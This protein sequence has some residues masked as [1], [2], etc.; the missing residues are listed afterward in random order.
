MKDEIRKKRGSDGN[1]RLQALNEWAQSELR[2]KFQPYRTV[3]SRLASMNYVQ[4]VITANDRISNR[5]PAQPEIESHIIQYQNIL[6]SCLNGEL[7][8]QKGEGFIEEIIALL[9]EEEKVSFKF[10][11]SS[12]WNFQSR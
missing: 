9:P 1:T 10:T 4:A 11:S 12:L 5:R 3:L 7:I 6:G 8:R 2:L